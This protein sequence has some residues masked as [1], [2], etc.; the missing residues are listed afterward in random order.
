MA[1]DYQGNLE[2]RAQLFK[3]LGHPMR[4]L[5]LN[6]ISHKPRHGQELAA[7]L[8]IGAATVSHHLSKLAEAGLLD[9]R[10]D[11]YYQ[12]YFLKGD[13]LDKTLKEVIQMP[14]PS[15][16]KNVET[17]AFK[18]K[19]LNTFLKNGRLTRLP[20][21]RKKQRVVL[22][23]LVEEFEPGQGYHEL[24]VNRILVEWHNDVASIRRAFIEERLM[25]RE[26][27]IYRRVMADNE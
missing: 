16:T 17:D 23:R 15:L 4:L 13:L 1:N 8:N 19:V 22:E 21:Q 27:N 3:A 26:R 12:M 2:A 5:I 10:K 9:S 20:T 25:T 18:E 24:E 6:L 7:I 11:Q 14:Q